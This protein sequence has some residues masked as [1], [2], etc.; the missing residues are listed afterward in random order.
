MSRR[1]TYL[2]F[3]NELLGHFVGRLRILELLLLLGHLLDELLLLCDGLSVG[4]GLSVCLCLNLS[5]N[6]LR[7]GI[8]AAQLL[9]LI[10]V[11]RLAGILRL[12]Q[13]IAALILRLVRL[14]DGLDV[15]LLHLRVL[16]L[17]LLLR[18]LLLSVGLLQGQGALGD[19]VV[20]GA[21]GALLRGRVCRDRVRGAR[22]RRILIRIR[23]ILGHA[24]RRAA[25]LVPKVVRH[26]EDRPVLHV[27]HRW[28]LQTQRSR[29]Q[30]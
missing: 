29:S 9:L 3:V 7:M 22:H 20:L 27:R 24:L 14:V 13:L 21:V 15:L 2:Q 28:Y 16:L 10:V 6:L 1:P 18:L 12:P 25:G 19:D 8:R 26:V 11:G 23:Q 4:L 17:L 30:I 5:L